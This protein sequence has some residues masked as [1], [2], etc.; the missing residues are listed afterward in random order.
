MNIN[1]LR[2]I[3]EI[4]YS[5][6][7]VEILLKNDVFKYASPAQISVPRVFERHHKIK[8]RNCPTE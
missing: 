5:I 3:A 1:L 2:G 4:I 8:K 7:A 6:Q